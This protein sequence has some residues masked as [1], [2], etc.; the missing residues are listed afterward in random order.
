MKTYS[1]LEPFLDVRFHVVISND[2]RRADRYFDRHGCEGVDED[3]KEDSGSEAY[4]LIWT[5]KNK[6]QS[7]SMI[8]GLY[9][10]ENYKKNDLIHELTHAAVTIL[11]RKQIKIDAENDECLARYMDCLTAMCIQKGLL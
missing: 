8:C 9:L 3:K 11:T 10:R 5:K 6:N 7:V 2:E 1:F 4:C